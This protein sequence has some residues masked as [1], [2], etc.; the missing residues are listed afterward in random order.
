MCT[1]KTPLP[2][3]SQSRKS[4]ISKLT[5]LSIVWFSH[6]LDPECFF[7]K[8]GI[9]FTKNQEGHHEF[10]LNFGQLQ[11]SRHFPI[12]DSRIKLNIFFIH[13]SII[14]L[15][16]S[17]SKWIGNK[18]CIYIKKITHVRTP[19]ISQHIVYLFIYFC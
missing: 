9:S 2:R 4:F 8:M 6:P 18:F 1:P 15:H 16:I 14:Y 10:T 5:N 13:T 3:K 12:P 7:S 17:S 11:L 19:S